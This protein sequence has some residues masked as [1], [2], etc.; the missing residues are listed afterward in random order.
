MALPGIG[1]CQV[2]GGHPIERVSEGRSLMF[3]EHKVLGEEVL[4]YSHSDS[5]GVKSS[6]VNKIVWSPDG[7][8]LASLAHSSDQL[9]LWDVVADKVIRR[10]PL[11]QALHR[12]D[13][14]L[15][16]TGDGKAI[17]VFDYFDPV[18]YSF[19]LI[20]GL[21][22][23]NVHHV[24]GPAIDGLPGRLSLVAVPRDGNKV[25][26]LLDSRS[27]Q[28]LSIFDPMTWQPVETVFTLTGLRVPSYEYGMAISPD[29]QHL[30]LLKTLHIQVPVKDDPTYTQ[31]V[32]GHEYQLVVWD[33]GERRVS[34][35]IK[36][37][38][39][40]RSSWPSIVRFS[41][42]GHQIVVGMANEDLRPVRI[43]DVASGHEARSYGS[44]LDEKGFPVW[45]SLH[46]LDWSSDGQ[47]IAFCGDDHSVHILDATS[48]RVVDS[49]RTPAACAAVAFSP[50]GTRLAY[51][52]NHTVI[53]RDILT[54]H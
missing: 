7:T 1:A 28:N 2:D 29:G 6:L 48:G 3:D 40:D 52:A 14:P 36:I 38:N 51:G 15:T 33:V 8:R 34:S 54:R 11:G 10:V 46:G 50:D 17:V 18:S 4:S 42:N 20:D 35:S 24:V 19:S 25:A 31:T 13:P 30:A 45:G 16:F 23:E 47:F 37:D 22:G 49:I 53:L 32:S 44:P 26:M 9:I 5:R 12:L 43:Y 39:D 27:G 41:P 21:T